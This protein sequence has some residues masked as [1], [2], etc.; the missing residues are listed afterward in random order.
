MKPT[1]LCPF[2]GQPMEFPLAF[3]LIVL[4]PGPLWLL[5][6][7]WKFKGSTVHYETLGETKA[8]VSVYVQDIRKALT[9]ANLP[10]VIINEKA[11]GYRLV[12]LAAE[13]A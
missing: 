8:I 2:C 13:A 10:W 3:P 9:V 11:V 6:M 7:L 5:F 12:H 1:R 4:P